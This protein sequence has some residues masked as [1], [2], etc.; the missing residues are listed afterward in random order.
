MTNLEILQKLSMTVSEQTI[1]CL[2]EECKGC[3]IAVKGHG[4]EKTS[5]E[6]FHRHG[7]LS[8]ENEVVYYATVSSQDLANVLSLEINEVGTTITVNKYREK[9][10][11]DKTSSYCE[12]REYPLTERGF[13]QAFEF[14]FGH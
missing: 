10:I 7:I 9:I 14:I 4:G 12:I 1:E 2:L 3:E 13:E 8:I 5:L 6:K 11:V